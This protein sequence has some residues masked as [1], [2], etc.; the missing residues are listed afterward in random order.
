MSFYILKI[1]DFYRQAFA[2][3]DSSFDWGFFFG[4]L[5]TYLGVL[6]LISTKQK[7]GFELRQGDTFFKTKVPDAISE[8][9][10]LSYKGEPVDSIV[11]TTIFLENTGNVE[12]K[13]DDFN[14]DCVLEFSEEIGLLEYS[15]QCSD[16]FTI[17]K[18]TFKNNKLFLTIAFI[19]PKTYIKIEIL[20]KSHKLP[21]VNFSIN[22]VRGEKKVY[23]LK[24]FSN[25]EHQIGMS[26]DSSFMP[27]WFA[28]CIGILVG[29]AFLF[30]KTFNV[31]IWDADM[32]VVIP[33]GWAA[34]FLLAAFIPT[35]IIWKKVYSQLTFVKKNW[36]DVKEWTSIENFEK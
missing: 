21:E 32:N 30:A 13:N 24:D 1:V 35:Y 20:Y 27:I 14:N 7:R 11:S 5:G 25:A 23:N 4:I 19:E 12:L 22:I 2:P 28:I 33:F 8:K 34:L 26:H 10:K 9:V 17:L 31:K 15:I 3:I 6:S 36:F 16:K 29:L 18:S